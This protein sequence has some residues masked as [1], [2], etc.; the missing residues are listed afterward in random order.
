[1]V[2]NNWNSND[3]DDISLPLH[4][5]TE[6]LYRISDAVIDSNG[7]IEAPVLP[8][9][10]IVVYPQMISPLFVGRAKSLWAIEESQSLNQTLIALTQ[11]E[12]D[13]DRPGPDDFFPIGVEMAVG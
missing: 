12:A 6:E 1:M 3:D 11:M 4:Q 9:R 8:L 5:R 2:N 13:R 10:D 7:I